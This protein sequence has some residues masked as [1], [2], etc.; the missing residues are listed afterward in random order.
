VFTA[1]LYYAL[2]GVRRAARASSGNRMSSNQPPN[3]KLSFEA[4]G[5]QW[6]IESNSVI[7]ARR[8]HEIESAIET[9]IDLFDTHY[10]RFR[11]DSL[12][13]KISQA[14][15]T[16]RLPPDAEKLMAFYC[17]LYDATEGKLTPLAGDLLVEAG[18]DAQYSLQP[19]ATLHPVASWDEAMH[20]KHPW[21]TMRQAHTLDFGAAGKGYI[22]DIIG[23]LL[24]E[25]GL[26]SFIIDASG[27]LLR[28]TPTNDTIR[29]GLSHPSDADLVIGV[30]PLGSGSICGSAG[31]RRSWAGLH[32]IMDPVAAEPVSNIIASWVVAET[33]MLADGI[34]TALFLA[35]PAK[36]QGIF[37]FEY[38]IVRSDFSF[39][40]SKGFAAELFTK[41]GHTPHR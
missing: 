30:A 38:C 6:T 19:E 20:Y 24:E 7:S 26:D 10:S 11:S 21:L 17:Q 4:I 39:N 34:A 37:P 41:I 33:A 31:N 18:Y 12:V 14:P 16:Y 35:D 8:W 5:T 13:T 1:L 27:D 25:A 23:E 36:L 40:H 15:G 3:H 9:R 2:V 28:K 22:V 29:I 32:H